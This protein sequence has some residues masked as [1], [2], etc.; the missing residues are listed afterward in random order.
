MLLHTI[1]KYGGNEYIALHCIALH[2]IAL[3]C[4]VLH[5]IALHCIALYCIVSVHLSRHLVASL[6]FKPI[7]LMSQTFLYIIKLNIY[8]LIIANS[9]KICLK[10]YSLKSC[11]LRSSSRIRSG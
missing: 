8:I 2:C 9:L 4:I 6:I 10:N 11:K 3:Y 1:F 7:T 5:Y